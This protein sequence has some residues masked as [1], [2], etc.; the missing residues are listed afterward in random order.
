M[1]YFFYYLHKTIVFVIIGY[2]CYQL[3]MLKGYYNARQ[4]RRSEKKNQF[5]YIN[6]N[7][8]IS[9][10]KTEAYLMTEFHEYRISEN[11]NYTLN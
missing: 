7:F 6:K 1:E 2:C 3:G 11:A 10:L 5:D 9:Y 4:K 8:E